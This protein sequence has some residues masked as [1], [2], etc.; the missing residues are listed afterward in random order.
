[1]RAF[2]NGLISILLLLGCVL[3]ESLTPLVIRGIPFLVYCRQPCGLQRY[4]NGGI[5]LV[6]AEDLSLVKFSIQWG[7]CCGAQGLFGNFQRWL[8]WIVAYVLQRVWCSFGRKEYLEL[9]SLRSED[10]GRQI[11]RLMPLMPTFLRRG[12]AML[13]Q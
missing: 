9:R 3:D 6:S 10:I 5:A 12:W 2:K 8:L 4:W 1:M 11:S 13:I 7:K